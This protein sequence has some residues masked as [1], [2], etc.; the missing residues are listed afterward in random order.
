M[1]L[2]C[3]TSNRQQY[4]EYKHEYKWEYKHKTFIPTN[5]S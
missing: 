1:A 5:A 4:H 2:S 3:I